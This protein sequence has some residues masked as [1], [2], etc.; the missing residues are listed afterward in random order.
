MLKISEQYA[1]TYNLQFSADPNQK[2]CKTKCT[3]FLKKKRELPRLYLCGNPLPWAE[4]FKHLGNHIA[5]ELNGREYN[6]KLRRV[7][8]SGIETLKLLLSCH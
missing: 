8:L 2:K 7:N 3:A 1:E 6:M 4:N 5:N